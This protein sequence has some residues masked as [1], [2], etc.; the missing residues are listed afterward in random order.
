MTASRDTVPLDLSRCDP[1][2]MIRDALLAEDQRLAARDLLLCWLLRLS[3]RIDAADAARF[4]IHAYATL[5]RRSAAARE[6]DRLLQ[7][8]AAWPRRRLARLGRPTVVRRV[9]SH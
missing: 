1:G 7:E 9:A 5:P 6:L 3:V 2:A 4:L 8:T